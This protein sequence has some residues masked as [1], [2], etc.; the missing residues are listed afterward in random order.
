MSEVLGYVF[1]ID[2]D[3]FL[4]F[5]KYEYRRNSEQSG[6]GLVNASQPVRSEPEYESFT[7]SVDI[8]SK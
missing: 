7:L 1:H 8:I 4:S 5:V 2:K 3:N 6:A